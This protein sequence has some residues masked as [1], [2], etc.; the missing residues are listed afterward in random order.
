MRL[1]LDRLK[2][3]RFGL[4]RFRA[5]RPD[6]AGFGLGNRLFALGRGGALAGW[7]VDWYNSRTSTSPQVPSG[8]NARIRVVYQ[9]Y[10]W[11]RRVY[12]D[13]RST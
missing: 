4:G 13:L 7:L 1:G 12:V 5:A 11:T 10:M 9:E 2:F 8:V 3:S 6:F